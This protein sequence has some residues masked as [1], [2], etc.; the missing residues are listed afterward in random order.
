MRKCVHVEIGPH[1]KLGTRVVGLC[2][3][4]ADEGIWVQ[5]SVSIRSAVYSV[6]R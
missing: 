5:G 6:C 4:D 1:I 2:Q 3:Q